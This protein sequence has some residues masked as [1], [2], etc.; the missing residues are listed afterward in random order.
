MNSKGTQPYIYMYPLICCEEAQFPG[1]ILMT[2]C[3][4]P[5]VKEKLKTQSHIICV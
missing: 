4:S 3:V 2:L 1:E 5:G